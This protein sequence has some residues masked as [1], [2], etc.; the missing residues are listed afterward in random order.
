MKTKLFLT[1]AA[2]ATLPVAAMAEVELSFYSGIQESPHAKV[3]G[4][5][6]DN[7]VS[8][9]LAFTAGWEG[10]SFEMPP[11]Y[12]LRATWWRSENWGWGVEY[13]HSKVYA[14]EETL[15]DNGYSR[16]E[17]TDGLNIATLNATYRMPNQWG[18]VT[19][20]AGAGIGVA[21]PHV[22]IQADG[23]ATH[24]WEYQLTGPAMRLY[25]GAKYDLNADWALFGE[26]QF[27]YS[28]HEVELDNGGNMATDI[29]T[30]AI[31]IGVSYSF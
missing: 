31:N 11:Y 9:N 8:Q 6:P 21:V 27:S 7:A 19:P 4:F 10:K 16:L 1:A 30:N 22:D 17:F 12:G 26:Y 14:D 28:Q 13:T 24:T 18:A 5:D 2:L 29:I 20:Y 23:S 15:N 25:A 3:T